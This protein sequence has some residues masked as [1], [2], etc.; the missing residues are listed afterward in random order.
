MIFIIMSRHNFILD[1]PFL[2][3]PI[4]KVIFV[5]ENY[6]KLLFI[7]SS[8]ETFMIMFVHTQKHTEEIRHTIDHMPE[9]Q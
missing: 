3:K 7:S 4:L 8:Q 1:V 6:R 9:V 2:L 5:G